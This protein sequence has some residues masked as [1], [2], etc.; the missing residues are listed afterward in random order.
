[1]KTRR[2]VSPLYT[3]NKKV[4][5]MFQRL[6][7]M[8]LLGLSISTLV[9]A[10]MPGTLPQQVAKLTADD[11]VED[12]RFGFSVAVSG[13]TVLVGA[14]LD[15]DDG[16]RSGSAYIFD[17]DA[18][19][20]GSW[21]QVTKLTADDAA[22]NDQFGYSVAISGTTA[23]VGAYLE[24]GGSI[25]AGSAYIFERDE[26]GAGNWGQ[27]A[28]LT[29]DDA[30][31]ENYFGFSVAISGTTALVGAY[32]N[33]DVDGGRAYIFERDEGGA[34]N[35][36]QVAKLNADD[37]AADDRF[38]F[39]V[40]LS[41]TTALV[42]AWRDDDGAT[43]SGSAYVFERDAGGA[44]NW[45]Q[46]AK[47]TADDA[48]TEDFFGRSVALSETTALIGASWDD[49]DGTDSGSAYIF[50]RDEGGAENW[51][52]VTK[53]TADDAAM[54][55]YFGDSVALSGTT[56]LVGAV[57]ED[58]GGLDSGSAYIFERDEGGAGNWGQLAKITAADA[59]V[60]DI[61]GDS[62]ALSGTTALVGA[63][64]NDDAGFESGSAYVFSVD[65][66]VI[67]QDGFESGDLS[68]WSAS[69]P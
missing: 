25:S 27:V 68:V 20:S 44:G 50:E 17:R 8:T 13:T 55:D 51:G 33:D 31:L 63:W 49:N 6:A 3:L 62:V 16:D 69:S 42:G 4:T 45:G 60:A 67:F 1:M 5:E 61:F 24:D 64:S 10:G 53:L 21:A 7:L 38:G 47:L 46:V 59:A 36:G 22:T 26:G 19:S 40:A 34:G 28:K 37:A 29:A 54:E 15:D 9:F 35:W 11:A 48:G 18:G 12:D 58:E 56:A 65:G 30:A 66:G 32:G 39:S 14:H 41:G 43:D 52:Q 2:P 23:L 57:L